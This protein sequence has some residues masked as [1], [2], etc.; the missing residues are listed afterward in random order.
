MFTTDKL[1]YRHFDRCQ[2]GSL[3]FFPPGPNPPPY[4]PRARQETPCTSAIPGPLRKEH[5]RTAPPQKWPDSAAASH[6]FACLPRTRRPRKGTTCRR[7]FAQ[8]AARC[9]LLTRPP[10]AVHDRDRVSRRLAD[11]QQIGKYLRDPPV[12][13]GRASIPLFQRKGFRGKRRR[14]DKQERPSV[15]LAFA[16]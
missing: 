14:T 3:I 12:S 13:L 9:F 6:F 10:S 4:S 16:I 1:F 7:T 11:V 15:A 2:Q 5:E 8:I